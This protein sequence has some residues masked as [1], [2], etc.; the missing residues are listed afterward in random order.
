MPT[1]TT[2]VNSDGSAELEPVVHVSGASSIGRPV[3]SA[4]SRSFPCP[5]DKPEV[6]A[7]LVAALVWPVPG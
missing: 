3:R 5:A 2:F 7:D 1:S 6:T 4:R